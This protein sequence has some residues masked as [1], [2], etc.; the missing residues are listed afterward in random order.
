MSEPILFGHDP[1]PNIVA[2][3]H[4]DDN[5]MRVYVR[6]DNTVVSE[7]HDFF[8]FFLIS[9]EHYLSDYKR[10]HWV[11]LLEG[12]NYF[13]YI[14]AFTRWFDMFDCIRYVM[15]RYNQ[16]TG[17]NISSFTDLPIIRLRLD[18]VSQYLIQTGKTCYK[19][20]EFE[21]IY[22]IQIYIE[23]HKK[24]GHRYSNPERKE[25]EIKLIGISDSKGRQFIIG[26][27]EKSEKDI[28]EEFIS[29]VR[30]KDPDIIE[31][32]YLHNFTIP[33]FI[34]RC[35]INGCDFNVGRDQSQPKII[36][37]NYL[38][39]DSPIDIATYTIAGR[40][41]IDTHLLLQSYDLTHKTLGSYNLTTASNLLGY[42]SPNNKSETEILDEENEIEI[43]INKC[44]E[45]N[46][47][48]KYIIDLILPAY[49]E[50]V[51][52][53][54]FSLETL[55][56]IG[57]ASKIESLLKR[58]YVRNRHSIPRPQSPIP[59]TGSYPG[60]FLRGVIGS[61]LYVE[62]ELM[63]ATIM[64]NEEYHPASDTLNIFYRML[65]ELR[66]F[67]EALKKNYQE[68]SSDKQVDI[69]QNTFRFLIDSAF[70][71]LTYNRGLFND[72]A[73]ANKIAE[74][75]QILLKQLIESIQSR[76]GEII[77]ADTEG[78]F[79]VPPPHVK[80]PEGEEKFIKRI[81]EDIP[82]QYNLLIGG[83]YKKILSYKKKNY[84]TIDYDNRM[85]IKGSALISKNLK[86]FGKNYIQQCVECL[87]NENFK[88]LHN[89]Y[90]NIYR[91]IVNH[92]WQVQDFM[93]VETL[94]ESLERYSHEIKAESR[95]RSAA[96]ELAMKSDR[97][98]K[99]GDKIAYYITGIDANIRTFENC[100]LAEEWNPLFPDENTAYYLK[101]L[102]D[103]SKKF[104]GFFNKEDY[105]AIFTTEEM[106]DFSIE[107]I[108]IINTQLS[109]DQQTDDEQ[110][111]ETLSGDHTIWLA[112]D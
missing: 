14:V 12:E 23:T 29:F 21:D 8:P 107:S 76:G 81:N 42:E 36:E 24:P 31:G 9:E 72:Y 2:V 38:Q 34:K 88:A 47:R 66:E 92:N 98:W 61:G 20:M 40:Q 28:L 101:N 91:D 74:T 105:A 6:K 51:K 35:E 90:I 25:D 109:G 70:G 22:R 86:R 100:K 84:A 103:F 49:F 18:P 26:K 59:K 10:K 7:D 108:K 39:V 65:K 97:S 60:V 78:I 4:I 94:K 16:Q 3:Q 79:F 30:T 96:Y 110:E 13:R 45:Y 75:G 89:L 85:R 77:E 48:I 95:N 57:S 33:Y 58:E 64:I 82:N 112:D 68:S 102:E 69:I 83:R 15:T 11:K 50:Q 56:K 27:K 93:R 71:Y 111:K 80:D 54:P 62:I 43:L 63:F 73:L 67:K 52:I 41:L 1:Y 46:D 32:H 106:L 55:I 19:G 104:E 5:K 17:K 99:V 37:P 44:R 87:L 53:F